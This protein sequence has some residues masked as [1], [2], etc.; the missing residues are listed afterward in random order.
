MQL[1]VHSSNHP[2]I[3]VWLLMVDKVVFDMKSESTLHPYPNIMWLLIGWYLSHCSAHQNPLDFWCLTSWQAGVIHTTIFAHP[4]MH[5]PLHSR[6]LFFAV[7][8]PSGLSQVFPDI[9]QLNCLLPY[10]AAFLSFLHWI[11][12][13]LILLWWQY[14]C[15]WQSF[16]MSIPGSCDP[17]SGWMIETSTC[18][19]RA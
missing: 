13:A 3:I 8:S 10:P 14:S 18:M 17:K 2:S 12:C 1:K 7:F 11:K 5:Q 4:P 19:T 15:S 9:Y 6:N 16:R